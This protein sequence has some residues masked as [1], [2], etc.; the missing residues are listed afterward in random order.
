[1][2]LDAE[3]RHIHPGI[4]PGKGRQMPGCNDTDNSQ[5]AIIV[6]EGDSGEV[7][8]RWPRNVQRDFGFSLW[9]LQEGKRPNL[10]GRPM[11][12]IGQGVF[13]L[14]AEDEAAWYR[15]IYLSKIG[16]TIYVLDCFTKKTRKTEKNDLNRARDRLLNVRL[17]LQKEKIDAKRKR[18]K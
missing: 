1:L 15:L 18:G 10:N 14:K 6:W 11:Q 3:H 8:K 13:E 12:S 9:N 2:A 16:T 5:I 4:N 7:L 17:R